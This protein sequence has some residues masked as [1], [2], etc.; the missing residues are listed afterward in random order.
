MPEKNKQE[1]EETRS[2]EAR[3]V[4]SEIARVQTHASLL[5]PI[6]M[7]SKKE[8]RISRAIVE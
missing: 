7:K 2:R 5:L 6:Y 4:P 1:E 8:K 3:V